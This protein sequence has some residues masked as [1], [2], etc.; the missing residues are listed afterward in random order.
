MSAET[1][2]TRAYKGI[3]ALAVALTAGVLSASPARAGVLGDVNGD[4][5]VDVQD[6]IVLSNYLVGIS[7][8]IPHPENADVNGD[9]VID[10]KDALLILQLAQGLRTTFTYHPTFVL[11]VMP[12][13]G[14]ANVPLTAEVSAIFSNPVSTASLPGNFV[15]IDSVTGL[16][17]SGTFRSSQNGTTIVFAPVQ[18]LAASRSYVVV[19]STGI[20]DTFGNHVSSAVVAGFKTQPLGTMV[21]TSVN[22]STATLSVLLSSPIAV[23]LFTSTGAFAAT[24]PVVFTAQMGNGTFQPSGLRQVTI[25]TDNNGNAIMAYKTGN[26]AMVNTVAVSAVGF[27]TVPVFQVQTMPTPAVNLRLYTGSNQSG[28]AG[29]PAPLPLIV[30]AT[31]AGDDYIQGA[32]VTFT[33]TQ[34]QGS[35]GGQTSSNVVTDSTGTAAT[36]FTFGASSG[37]IQ[38]QASF[39][40][41]LGLPPQFNLNDLLPQPSSQTFIHG[42]V[43]DS[44]SLQPLGNIYVYLTDNPSVWERSDVN[45]SFT[46]PTSSGPHVVEVDGFESGLIGGNMYPTV[47]YPVNAVQGQTTSLG[48]SAMLPE[49]DQ[50]SYIDVSDIVGGTLTIRAYPSWQLYIAPG[51]ATFQNGLHTG[52]IYASFVSHDT[53]PMPVAGGKFSRFDDTVQPPTVT[54]T[55]PA[56]VTF[57]NMDNLAP[58]TV[59]EIFT[60]DYIS[61]AFKRTGSGMVSADGSV[62]QSLPGQGINEGGWHS[63]PSPSPP[64]TSS[65]GGSAPGCDAAVNFCGNAAAFPPGGRFSVNVPALCGRGS[66][67]C[68]AGSGAGSNKKKTVLQQCLV[69][70]GKCTTEQIPG[71][72]G[73]PDWVVFSWTCTYT[74]CGVTGSAEPM[75]SSAGC[76]CPTRF[77][78]CPA[79]D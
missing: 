46:L 37:T 58:G 28:S 79:P 1:P 76:S 34:G 31:D 15:V 40:G 44:N 66:L 4:G 56:Q 25:L 26:Q 45:G 47:S 51:Q 32:T 75:M 35:F 6:A 73:F 24:V 7:T 17:S 18:T 71:P 60:L 3:V 41:M 23:Q 13:S 12:S 63:A 38:V 2:S 70:E 30:Q 53:I 69:S 21:L 36:I 55:P 74:C 61:G 20:T 22:N 42:T 67:T 19:L 5:K 9:G 52:R 72:P 54:F 59:T 16:P 49:L 33:I 43:I 27:S 10:V 78:A 8:Y 57:P 48:I 64:G 11:A 39:P 77:A 50:Q 62:T 29:N 65:F 68:A 14:T